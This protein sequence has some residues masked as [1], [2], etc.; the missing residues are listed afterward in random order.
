M[1]PFSKAK[2]IVLFSVLLFSCTQ[3]F[4]FKNLLDNNNDPPLYIYP[5]EVNLYIGSTINFYVS[6][7]R[8]PYTFS[9]DQ[10]SGSISEDGVYNAPGTAGM[11]T[12]EVEDSHGSRITARVTVTDQQLTTDY[13]IQSITRNNSE[14]E[15]G[16]L[17]N[18]SF[19][20]AN[21]GSS[22]GSLN[23]FWDAYVSLDSILDAGDNLVS[24]GQISPLASGAESSSIPVA[25]TWPDATG[26][27][28]LIIELRSADDN[29]SSNNRGTIGL[30]TITASDS[31]IDYIVSYI[32]Q[33][34]PIVPAGT[35]CGE[36]FDIINLGG[37]DGSVA[38]NWSAYAS[39]DQIIDGSDFLIASETT[40]F[41]GVASGDT[42]SEINIT[43]SWPV[44]GGTY[45]LL[46]EISAT[47]ETV[48]G[49][50]FGSRGT[51]QIQPPPDY[52]V[53]NVIYQPQ[54][55]TEASFSSAGEY[56]FEISEISGNGGTQPINWTLYRSLDAVLDAEDPQLAS[57]IISSLTANGTSGVISFS[58]Q[59][60]P[61]FGSYYSLIISIDSADDS[62]SLNN[63]YITPSTITVPE[64][65][66]EEAADNSSTGP[67]SALLPNVMEIEMDGG[68]LETGQLLHIKGQMDASGAFDTYQVNTG[69]ISTLEI[70]I[71]W[72]TGDNAIDFYLW[73]TNSN[74][75][76]SNDYRIDSEPLVPT[77]PAKLAVIANETYYIGVEFLGDH[78]GSDYKIILHG[79]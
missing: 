17:I 5:S 74:E 62:D 19:I 75:E 9:V 11:E 57:D 16:T 28:Y 7:G 29:D 1:F 36:T 31:D 73:D 43:G 27:F 58:D 48:T 20:I 8:A 23:I 70:Y 10:G 42:Q 72:S 4:T 21:Q 37:L 34:Y 40:P 47:D 79:K 52:T 60:W 18:E 65:F 49:N 12:I 68:K 66:T 22:S 51:F 54:G 38:I 61:S 3:P 32:S 50:N 30:F 41:Y 78:P 71:T 15:S 14:A 55:E 45:Y 64:I 67:T 2:Y 77:P 35:L 69:D 56:S 33:D 63:L 76:I 46:I 59:L 6:G 39:T 24:S 25:G 26:L 13:Y 53:S 44:S